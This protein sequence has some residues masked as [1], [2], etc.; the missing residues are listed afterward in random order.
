[1]V[2]VGPEPEWS[3]GSCELR[4]MAQQVPAFCQPVGNVVAVAAVDRN[5]PCSAS[6]LY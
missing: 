2:K 6:E 1:M 4:E 3:V 5:E